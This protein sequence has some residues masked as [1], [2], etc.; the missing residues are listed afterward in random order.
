MNIKLN[1]EPSINRWLLILVA[2]LLS[3]LLASF[4]LIQFTIQTVADPSLD[5]SRAVL[6]AA[7]NYFPSA[8][9]LQA[10]LAANL[11]EARIDEAQTHEQVAEL[12]YA[13]AQRAVQ[14]APKVFE[15]QVLLAVTAEARG[16][17]PMAET[18]LQQAVQLAPQRSSVQW[19]L[20][21]LWL[22]MGKDNEASALLGQ[23]VQRQPTYLPEALGLLW[24]TT[25]GNVARVQTLIGP[26]VNHQLEFCR[27]LIAQE[28]FESAAQVF[29]A[30]N[31]PA[32]LDKQTDEQKAQTE[33]S[34][35]G[36]ILTQLINAGK[37]E[38]AAQLWQQAFAKADEW[39]NG[40]IWNG[41]FERPIQKEFTQ[42]DWNLTSNNRVRVLV[43]NDAAHGGRQALKLSYL[44][45]ETTRL[46]SE[47]RQL[48]LVQPG[49]RY[50]LEFFWRAEALVSPDGPYV[51]LVRNDNQTEVA[52]SAPVRNGST[53]WQ[54][55]VVEFQ[56]PASLTSL[57][58]AIKQT[59]KFSYTEPT[60][61]AVWFDDFQLREL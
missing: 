48:V 5:V 12:A 27:F 50:R 51:A 21:N 40:K 25:Q 38:S 9:V 20:A 11:I 4:A 6:E 17:L 37:T 49:K 10:R 47:I 22:R 24:Q 7:S 43:A 61:G 39:G 53:D 35:R 60:K 59:P 34:L 36:Q 44:G 29:G 52:A 8:S 23:V 30:L 3:G 14:L 33:R 18:A 1:F 55:G 16:D 26:P 56:A 54:A 19:R 13:H 31:S 57:S 45:K 42:F 46:A 28:Q 58:I 15:N 41:D 32:L 2:G